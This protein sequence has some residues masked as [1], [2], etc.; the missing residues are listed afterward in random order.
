MEQGQVGTERFRPTFGGGLSASNETVSETLT[1]ESHRLEA[2]ACVCV[3]E[4]KTQRY[5]YL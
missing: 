5:L 4:L 3:S 2:C 1:D